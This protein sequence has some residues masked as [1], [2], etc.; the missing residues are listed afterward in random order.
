MQPDVC[1]VCSGRLVS[2]WDPNIDGHAA[3]SNLCG[4]ADHCTHPFSSFPF[5]R[6]IHD[7]YP[8][9]GKASLKCT[10]GC[11]CVNTAM[12]ECY[13]SMFTCIY[14]SQH[15]RS[16]CFP[17]KQLCFLTGHRVTP[18]KQAGHLLH[19]VTSSTKRAPPRL[20]TRPAEKR[21]VQWGR[22]RCSL[23]VQAAVL[24]ATGPP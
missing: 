24:T 5:F 11:M 18:C 10:H 7:S 16:L 21:Q 17:L 23:E 4:G 1:P 19:R 3:K 22:E 2:G 9:A 15:Q 12:R 20:P 6:N 8:S 14:V 13:T